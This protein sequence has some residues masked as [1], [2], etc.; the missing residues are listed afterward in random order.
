MSL[1][2]TDTTDGIRHGNGSN[3]VNGEYSNFKIQ[4][5]QVSPEDERAAGHGLQRHSADIEGFGSS[6]ALFSNGLS[7]LDQRNTTDA[8]STSLYVL[9][10]SSFDEES[11]R[12][13]AVALRD[14]LHLHSKNLTAAL[15]RGLAYTLGSRR[16]SLSWKA[17]FI[18]A[19]PTSL[20]GQLSGDRLVFNKSTKEPRLSFLFTG[21]G[22]QWHAMGREIIYRYPVFERSLEAASECLQRLGASWRLLGKFSVTAYVPREGIDLTFLVELMKNPDESHV[23]DASISQPLTTA[24]QIALVDLLVSWN[25]K[26]KAVTGHSSGEIAAAYCAGA[27]T[28][29]SALA[30]AYHRGR[31]ASK[32]KQARDGAMLAVALSAEDTQHLIDSLHDGCVSVACINSPSSVTVSGDR[33]GII[34]LHEILK[35]KDT[36]A[37]QLSVSVAY[38]SYHMQDIADEYLTALECLSGE[39]RHDIADVAYYSSLTGKRHDLSGLG[40][41]Y[42]VANMTNPVQFSASLQ[43]LLHGTKGPNAEVLVEIGPHSA[44]Q[45]PV[46]QILQRLNHDSPN[47][48]QYFSAL[49]RYQNALETSQH[50]A[51][52]LFARGVPINMTA[53]NFPEGSQGLSVLTDLPPYSWDH[54]T[55]YWAESAKANQSQNE[56]FTRSDLLGIRV[57]TSVSSE[58]EWRNILRPSDIPWVHDHVVQ[59]N[60]VY[61]AAGF[62]AMAIEAEHQHI[63]DKTHIKA[64]KLREVS[65][66]HALVLAEGID[67]VETRVS[68]RPYRESLRADS[69]VWNEFRISSS[70][71]GSL[72]TEH[73]RGLIAVEGWIEA[74]G[75]DRGQSPETNHLIDADASQ[76]QQITSQFGAQSKV[77]NVPDMYSELERIGLKFGPTF[78]NMRYACTSPGCCLAQMTIPDTA[79]RMPAHFEYPYVIHPATL[80]SCIHSIFPIDSQTRPKHRS[81]TPVPTFIEAMTVSQ[82]MS[83]EHGYCFDVFA[84]SNTSPP[85]QKPSSR[86]PAEYSITAFDQTGGDSGIKVK[87]DGLR[88]TYIANVSGDLDRGK[89]PDDCYQTVWQPDPETLTAQQA[90][91]LTRAF[92]KPYPDSNLPGFVQQAAYYYAE[93]LLQR[94]GDE[95][96]LLP[97]LLP[98]H[99]KYVSCLR[100]YCQD[101][102]QGYLG[103]FD[104]SDWLEATDEQRQGIYE[105]IADSSWGP[106]LSPIGRNLTQILSGELDP[107]SLMLDDNRLEHYYR[108]LEN[109]RQTHEQAAFYI[110]LLG[111]KNPHLKILEIGAGTGSATHPI[112]EALGNGQ[113]GRSP[114]FARYDFTD[115]SPAFFDQVRDEWA[116]VT[117]WRRV[118]ESG[119]IYH[120]S[121]TLRCFQ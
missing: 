18:A 63:K 120:E 3:H 14:Y 82:N 7:R 34:E 77:V 52:Q 41:A 93:E 86:G 36:F 76:F 55:S 74:A 50:L 58:P 69:D 23:H 66:G 11:G 49:V 71:D 103:E 78:A 25:I 100:R 39:N 87:M 48:V 47:H 84:R 37:R 67:S 121:S 99:E 26:A 108:T 117:P 31:L 81:E 104:T 22:A 57:H 101:V 92:R 38:H 21:Q 97:R 61:P 109:A 46:T 19:S 9:V 54:S 105:K 56:T 6:K 68:L 106:L 59:G 80:D 75:V 51:A 30:V 13:H 2:Q 20:A 94:I 5:D 116:K 42:W 28:Q 95:V 8:I 112:L 40:P 111:N 102:H 90:S 114:S 119:N 43:S 44:L 64:Y 1:L 96:E 118:L 35:S 10:I 4:V 17:A 33:T 12:R 85:G 89:R 16:S 15:F 29:A 115:I 62:L 24:I 88:V 72:W 45:G 83:K 79:E 65:V 107:L 32:V 91:E 27:L 73:S 53:V 98:H 113:D 110:S 60:L 70:A